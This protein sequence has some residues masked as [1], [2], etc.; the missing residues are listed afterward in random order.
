MCLA[1]HAAQKTKGKAKSMAIRDNMGVALRQDSV[2]GINDKHRTCAWMTVR[3]V[4]RFGNPDFIAI[5][6][7]A[8]ASGL[9]FWRY[10]ARLRYV[11]ALA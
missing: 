8:H 11:G 1:W 2:S 5:S 4:I 6:T 3:I 10:Y 7:I 9:L